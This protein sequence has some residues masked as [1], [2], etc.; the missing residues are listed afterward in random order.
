MDYSPERRG[1]M[2][3]SL[4]CKAAFLGMALAIASMC[5]P[6]ANTMEKKTSMPDKAVATKIIGLERAALD[7]WGNGDPDGFLE[8]YG[9]EVTYFA[10]DLEK[11]LDG[12]TAL[13]ATLV[14]IRGK[15]KVDRYDMIDPKVQ[16]HGD[17]ALLTFNIV[18][19]K[20]QDDDS[21]TVSSRWNSS[22]LYAKINDQ[23]KIV[24]SHWSLTKPEL[25]QASPQ[26]TPQLGNLKRVQDQS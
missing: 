3:N 14:P 10:P 19:Y 17:T 1:N 4:V 13:R 20:K 25:D 9:E 8:T 2:G 26:S 7:R 12:L 22:E 11:R 23:W 16:I 18:N 24:H 21:E 6:G 5:E 15:I